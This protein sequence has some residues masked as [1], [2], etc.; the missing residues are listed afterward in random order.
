M[1]RNDPVLAG[2]GAR[3]GLTWGTVAIGIGGAIAGLIVGFIVGF[4]LG[5]NFGS[6]WIPGNPKDR[7]LQAAPVLAVPGAVVFGVL[8][9]WLAARRRS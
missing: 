7:Y 2:R 1:S 4:I 3:R 9:F 5:A 8:A 6:D